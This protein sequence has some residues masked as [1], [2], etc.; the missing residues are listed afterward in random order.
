LNAT[1]LHVNLDQ[2]FP[3]TDP[4]AAYGVGFERLSNGA[5]VM[6]GHTGSVAG[7]EAAAYFYPSSEKGLILLRNAEYEQLTF[8]TFFRALAMLAD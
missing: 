6:V 1:T 3:E 2:A 4:N 8:R 7:Y 5:R